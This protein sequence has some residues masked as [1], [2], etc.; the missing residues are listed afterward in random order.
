MEYMSEN[1]ILPDDPKPSRADALRNHELL[2]ET[3]QLLFKEQGLEN[4]SMSAI[5]EAAGV[6]KGTLYRHFKNKSELA[7]ELLDQDMRDLQARMF[8]RLESQGDPLEDLRWFLEQI[9]RFVDRNSG[10]LCIA[11]SSSGDSG[12]LLNAPAHRWWRQTFRA[13]LAR[14]GSHFDLDY[15]ADILYLMVDA[16]TIRFQRQTLGYDLEKILAGLHAT[17]SLLSR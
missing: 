15:A 7:F 3:A 1:L 12:A 10:L 4:V 9:L 11:L 16:Q 17:L 14:A 6:G 8:R 2:L 5:A 13:L